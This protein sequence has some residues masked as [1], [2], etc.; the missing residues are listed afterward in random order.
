MPASIRGAGARSTSARAPKLDAVTAGAVD[1]ARAALIEEVGEAQ[2]GEHLGVRA[3]GDRVVTH[4]FATRL[5][6]YQGWHWSVTVTRASRQKKV[7][8]DEVVLLP[9]DDAIISP[10]WT[11][12][13]DRVRPGDM[14]PG[15]LL[16][17][18]SD[19]VRLA[20]AWFVGDDAVDPLIDP[21]SVR[22]VADEVAIGR[23]HV[24]SLEGR[25]AAAQRWYDGDGGPST[26][27]AQQAPGRCRGCGFMVWLAPPLGSLFGVCANAMANDDGKVVSFDHGCGAHSEARVKRGPDPTAPPVHDTVTVDPVVVDVVTTDA[28]SD[29]APADGVTPA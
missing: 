18:E 15:D 27:M 8:V 20:P 6:G 17:P 28:A 26:P 3:E 10:D 16:P 14:S 7:T 22:P 21:T 9:G 2:V 23:V 24:L 29:A 5:A 12:Y 13:K 11:P 25:D 4:V 1:V 19:D